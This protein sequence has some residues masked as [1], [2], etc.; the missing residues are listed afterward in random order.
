MRSVQH[1]FGWHDSRPMPF[2]RLRSWW[3]SVSSFTRRLRANAAAARSL[4]DELVADHGITIEQYEILSRLARTPD[5]RM[6][7][8]EIS[9][10][11]LVT[12]ANV[13]RELGDLERIHLVERSGEGQAPVVL[14]TEGGREK[15]RAASS[16]HSAQLAELLG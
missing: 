7:Q 3:A 5:G 4:N 13:D 14:L 10:P 8:A 16:R 11:P 12:A 6:L 9:E 2:S 15:V 1:L